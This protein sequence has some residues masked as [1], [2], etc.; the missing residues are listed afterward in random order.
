MWCGEELDWA[1]VC[2]DVCNDVC[3]LNAATLAGDQS[4]IPLIHTV[5]A[6]HQG[7]SIFGE[8]DL[9]EVYLQFPLHPDSRPYTALHGEINKICLLVAHLGYVICHLIFNGLLFMRF[10]L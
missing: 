9:A 7:C 4:Q 10:I 1:P 3:K 5:L 6:S 2:L 8:F